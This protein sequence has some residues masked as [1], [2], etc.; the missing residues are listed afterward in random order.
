MYN[1]RKVTNEFPFQQMAFVVSR[2]SVHQFP[3]IRNIW[4][5]F[6]LVQ[7][8]FFLLSSAKFRKIRRYIRMPLCALCVFAW[9]KTQSQDL[10]KTQSS[11][12]T[13]S[14]YFAISDCSPCSLC[15]MFSAFFASLRSLRL[16]IHC[17]F[18]FSAPLH[19]LR[20]CILCTF[21]FSAPL[22]SLRLCTEPNYAFIHFT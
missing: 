1:L 21:A 6:L 14:A 17:T 3:K 12:F 22:R 19:S 20:L 18:A 5:W 4:I 16:C 7:D 10:A 11:L 2:N 13:Y 9:N 15:F 8:P